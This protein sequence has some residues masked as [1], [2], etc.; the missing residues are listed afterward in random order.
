VVI[1]IVS[2]GATVLDDRVTLALSGGISGLLRYNF[3][4]ASIFSE[5]PERWFV[6]FTLAGLSVLNS[7]GHDRGG[8]DYSNTAFGL[9]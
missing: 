2:L 7:E 1:L 3:N 5:T 8:R 4:P 6:G 9:R